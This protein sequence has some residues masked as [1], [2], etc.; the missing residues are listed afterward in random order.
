MPSFLAE[1]LI[2]T[3]I[4]L[5]LNT[6]LLVAESKTPLGPFEVVN[7]AVE[8]RYSSPGDFALVVDDRSGDAF[9]AYMAFETWDAI[10]LE[11]LSADYRSTIPY[12]N[13]GLLTPQNQQ[14]PMMFK[15]GDTYYLTYGDTCC[16][17]KEGSNGRVLTAKHPL[18]PWQ[19]Q[20]YDID[21]RRQP[22]ELARGSLV[23]AQSS[24]IAIVPTIDAGGNVTTTYLYVGDRWG[25]APDGLKSHDF[26]VSQ[27]SLPFELHLTFHIVQYWH[28]LVFNDSSMPP[29]IDLLHFIASF[30]LDLAV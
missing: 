17:C 8:L 19:D 26:Q 12:T 13:T 28:P 2:S 20:L 4:A 29:S 7:S 14:S 25:S 22:I 6:S 21:R 9:I 10:T 1:P 15:R 27:L 5:Q 16:F 23:G 30:T 24:S 11:Q 3:L 18:G